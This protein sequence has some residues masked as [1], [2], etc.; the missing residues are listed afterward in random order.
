MTKLDSEN[1][2][3]PFVKHEDFINGCLNWR[4]EVQEQ[5]R[6]YNRETIA[7]LNYEIRQM[8]FIHPLHSMQLEFNIFLNLMVSANHYKGEGLSAN[9]KIFIKRIVSLL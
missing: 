7:A 5:K 4:A 3:D 6:F 9:G 8:S 2:L 1:L